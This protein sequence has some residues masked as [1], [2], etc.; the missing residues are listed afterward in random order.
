MLR[1]AVSAL[2]LLACAGSWAQSP[3]PRGAA[4]PEDGRRNQ[5]IERLVHEDKGNR[6]EEVR[7]AGQTQSISVQPKSSD[8]PAYEVTPST[9]TRGRVADERTNGAGGGQ[10]FWN[11]FNF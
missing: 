5:K 7:Y 6:I 2:F 4:A 11:V 1:A 3:D 10:R 8:M 9:P